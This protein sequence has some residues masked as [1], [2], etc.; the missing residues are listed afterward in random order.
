V[1]VQLE[2]ALGDAAL[3]EERAR[4][5]LDLA[6][7]QLKAGRRDEAIETLD[8]AERALT[9]AAA[10]QRPATRRFLAIQQVRAGVAVTQVPVEPPDFGRWPQP[11]E[12]LQAAMEQGREAFEDFV[13]TQF[14]PSTLSGTACLAVSGEAARAVVRWGRLDWAQALAARL[15]A[16]FGDG[17]DGPGQAALRALG[18]G[19]GSGW[20]ER[21]G[22]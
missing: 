22:Y 17:L 1:T 18:A 2:R 16:A 9:H 19:E 12:V 10:D 14:D 11:V 8:A 7:T 20:L 15:L 13:R 21:A 5:L 4:C 3:D 6:D